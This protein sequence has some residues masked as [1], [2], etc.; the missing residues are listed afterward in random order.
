MDGNINKTQNLQTPIQLVKPGIPPQP[1]PLPPQQPPIPP[2]QPP[3]PP[4]PPSKPEPEVKPIKSASKSGLMTLWIALGMFVAG[5]I[6]GI[7]LFITYPLSSS[8]KPPVK[9][10][11][12]T[13]SPSPTPIALP[14]D[15][16]EIQDCQDEKGELFAVQTDKIINPVYMVYKN[17]VI[18]LE[19]QLD[20]QEFVDGKY[21]AD[22]KTPDLKIDHFNTSYN[23]SS[24]SGSTISQV[25][26]DLYLVNSETSQAIKCEKKEEPT[27]TPT[28]IP[29]PTT[30]ASSSAGLKAVKPEPTK[31][32]ILNLSKKQQ[33]KIFQEASSQLGLTREKLAYFRIFGEDKIQYGL[34]GIGE[35]GANFAYKLNGKWLI[36][37]KGAEAVALC[38]DFVKIPKKYWPPCTDSGGENIEGY[39]SDPGIYYIQ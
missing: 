21:P 25:Y 8:T 24:Q 39:F 27:P 10:P 18:G 15:A 36:A 19:Y 32:E 38:S 37:Q 2:G 16:V 6:G 35:E 23:T 14:K 9:A 22:F 26:V 5:V 34:K 17:K 13:P 7:L 20:Q 33:D 3:L 30:G 28:A 31:A 4:A 12:V 1:K 29:M 11:V